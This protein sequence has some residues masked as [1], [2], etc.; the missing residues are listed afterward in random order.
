MTFV[1]S[2][3]RSTGAVI[4]EAFGAA[5]SA[6]IWAGERIWRAAIQPTR[7]SP[8]SATSAKPAVRRFTDA[9]RP[10][11]VIVQASRA[12]VVAPVSGS[13]PCRSLRD[14][15]GSPNGTPFLR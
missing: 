5:V 1:A 3:R 11:T 9:V 4:A 12:A 8:I 14:T 7:A 10:G 2:A 15:K 13:G 6:A